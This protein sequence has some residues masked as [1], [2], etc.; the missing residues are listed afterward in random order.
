MNPEAVGKSHYTHASETFCPSNLG[1][2][3]VSLVNNNSLLVYSYVQT[4]IIRF[5]I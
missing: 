5:K 2:V 4:I 3:T 1:C